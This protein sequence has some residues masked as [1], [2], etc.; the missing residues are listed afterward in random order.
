MPESYVLIGAGSAMFTRGLV[1]DLIRRRQPCR[2]ALVDIDPEA[3]AVAEALAAK[4]IA[5]GR[6]PI[7]L[8][9][10]TDRRDVL[11]GA[12]A[13][14]CTIGV[15]GRRAIEDEGRGEIVAVGREVEGVAT[16]PA[17]ARDK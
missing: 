12:T 1:A 16:A 9:A 10:A 3:L 11:P 4:M 15:G 8:V 17:E 5:A 6:A 14:I 2:L 7:S 13:V